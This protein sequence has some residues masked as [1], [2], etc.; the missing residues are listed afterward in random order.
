MWP[1]SHPITMNPT[2]FGPANKSDDFGRL[3]SG[4]INSIAM[5]EGRNAAA[6]EI[7]L[8]EKIGLS[9]AAIQ[10]YKRG[11]LPPEPNTVRMLAEAAVKR[12]YLNR[13]WLAR[14]LTLAQ[15][16]SPGALLDELCPAADAVAAPEAGLHNLPPPSYAQFVMRP[17]P[18]DEVVEA[19]RQRTAAVAV[20]SLGGMGKTSLV[21]E[22]AARCLR[23]GGD[24][25][26]VDA[27]VWLSDAERPGATTLDAVLDEIARTLR[28]DGLVERGL[29]DKRR[30]VEDA[31]RGRR[32]L[33]VLD[34]FETVADP[35]LLPWLLKLPE[36]SKAVLTTREYRREF[37]QGA[38]HVEL[39]GMTEPEARDFV[40]QRLLMLRLGP[41]ALTDDEM[42]HLIALT[43][44]NPK[45]MELALGGLKH[46]RRLIADVLDDLASARGEPFDELIERSWSGL[47]ESSRRVL[48]A[49]TLFAPNADRDALAA[50]ADVRPAAMGRAVERLAD[51]ALLDV[52]QTEAHRRPRF[53]LHPLVRSFAAAELA[54]DPAFADAARARCVDWYVAVASGVGYCRDDLDRLARLDPER[55]M[56]HTAVDWARRDERHAAV[57]ALA[58]GSGYYC[59]VRGLMGRAPDINLTAA[60]AARAL[61][62]PAEELRWLS[63]HVQRKA[64]AGDLR[65]VAGV[66]PRVQA[67]AEAYS[68][69]PETAEGYRHALATYHLADGRPA[70]AER[71]W[72]A[73][74]ALDGLSERSRLIAVRW[75]AGCLRETGRADEARELVRGALAATGAT[76]L[77]AV[78]ALQLLLC[79][80][81]A[82]AGGDGALVEAEAL[83]G[84]ARRAIEQHAI[85]RHVPDALMAEGELAAA[86][87]DAE[88][89]RDAFERAAE[90]FRRIGLRREL[91][92]AEGRLRGQT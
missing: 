54:R 4:A 75:L 83:L 39:R 43:G 27:V 67:L 22:V 73:L 58:E 14:F 37:R 12:G 60:E 24:E 68:L 35:A 79:R 31:L 1:P 69:P 34:N 7:S 15:Y 49:A 18:F 56:L 9:G 23:A 53:A 50:A 36:P 92:E 66:L 28:F 71:E 80:A 65:E 11:H 42:G 32:V 40:A 91:A 8:G 44:G 17:Q 5:Y 77:R 76:N 84:Q 82:E 38:W 61:R 19:L 59:Y 25:P 51:L 70:D 62:R 33:V 89:A 64:R 52:L 81:L 85:D 16:P 3:L 57:L 26:R 55:D 29:D 2:G 87:G 41:A 30:G 78:V 6:V 46:A 88:R 20:S 48:L 45:A 13:R 72:R 86:R 10:R 63:F 47:D 21:R 90:R 74:L